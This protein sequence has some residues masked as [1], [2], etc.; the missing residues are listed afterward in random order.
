MSQYY[1]DFFSDIN[2]L[3][4]G[5]YHGFPLNIKFVTAPSDKTKL[6]Q[7]FS[8]QRTTEAKEDRLSVDYIA[9]NKSTLKTT[10]HGNQVDSK[11]NIGTRGLTYNLTYIP[12]SQNSDSQDLS[13]SHTSDL[14]AATSQISSVE[15]VNFSPAKVGPLKLWLTFA[16]AWN[17]FNKDKA[18]SQSGNVKYENYFFGWNL[19]HDVVAKKFTDLA[20]NLALRNEKGDFHATYDHLNRG[21]TLGCYHKH[22][23]K[24][25]HY[26]SVFVD[27]DRKLKGA[28][29]QPAALNWAAEYKLTDSATVK[30]SIQ[31]DKEWLFNFA[32][33]H[34]VNNNLKVTFSDSL[35]IS[36]VAS[37]KG[38]T[39]YNFGT[40]LTWT[41]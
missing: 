26:Y 5:Y 17:S 37:G 41:I 6:S 16:L 27:V 38:A 22:G 4:K 10:C 28:F 24:A 9:N 11:L 29:G 7:T 33:S 19:T 21:V 31:V 15:A 34:R 12:K 14:E 8:V 23:A 1:T 20:F 13:F 36:Q 25:T 32:W 35:N 2:K 39:P 3:S 40:Q 30:S 18:L